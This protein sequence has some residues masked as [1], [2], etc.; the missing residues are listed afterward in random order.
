VHAVTIADNAL[1]DGSPARAASRQ[2]VRPVYRQPNPQYPRSWWVIGFSHEVRVGQ[3]VP[4]KVLER[5]L[6]LWRDSNGT[7]HCHD[8]ICP[9]LGANLGFGGEVR[10]NALVCPFHG[11]EFG[12]DGAVIRRPRDQGK[13]AERCRLI[14]FRI[15]E[16]LGT[17]FL[18]NGSDEPDHP[19]PDV[20]RELVADHPQYTRDDLTVL[21]HGYFLPYPAKWFLE[22]GPDAGH[23]PTVH[24]L[25]EWGEAEILEESDAVLRWRQ[26]LHEVKPYLSRE[27]LLQQYRA[28]ELTNFLVNAGDVELTA[29]A[30]GLQVLRLHERVDANR[31]RAAQFLGFF[32]SARAF[33]CWTPADSHHHVFRFTFV[34]PRIKVPV[35]GGLGERLIASMLER[36]DWGGIMQDSAI[37]IHRQEPPNPCYSR[38]DRCLIKFRRLWDSRLDDRSLWEGDNIHSNGLRAGIRWPDAPVGDLRADGAARSVS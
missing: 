13:A 27:K 26:R 22:N 6:V 7:L 10:N 28:G 9:H 24:K 2:A 35:V 36:R 16:H 25:G 5:D 29:Y 20:V 11:F 18:W 31:G 33:L 1:A 12:T 8:A 21:H 19:V 30:G 23:F 32:E 4:N 15:E 34:M 38:P 14:N 3:A 17:I 37:M